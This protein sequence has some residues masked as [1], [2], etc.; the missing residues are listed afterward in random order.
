MEGKRVV[1]LTEL[2]EGEVGVIVDFS[3]R[4]P[5]RRGWGGRMKR[6]QRCGCKGARLREVLKEVGLTPGTKVTVT[7]SSRFLGPIEI[8]VKDAKVLLGRGMAEKILVEVESDR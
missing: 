8:L 6:R 7:K 3:P 4:P 1:P 2:K 5:E